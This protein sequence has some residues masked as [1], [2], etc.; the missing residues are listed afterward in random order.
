MQTAFSIALK[1]DGSP[2]PVFETD[3]DRT[4]FVARF[5]IHP[6]ALHR[7]TKKERVES[8][9]PGT[10]SGSDKDNIKKI[11]SLCHTPQGIT[12]LMASLS[13]TNRTKFRNKYLNRIIG[14]GL[15]EMIIPDKPQ[16]SLQRY[17]LTVKGK[18]WLK[19]QW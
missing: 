9:K 8:G 14:E 19:G 1:P 3:D 15:L 7:I 18:K 12:D 2:L 10:K 16:S 4:Y 11:L 6:K 13:W 5:P 17:R